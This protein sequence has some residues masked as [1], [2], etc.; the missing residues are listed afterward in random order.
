MEQMLRDLLARHGRL[1]VTAD[2]IG[3]ND[4]LHEAG[5]TSLATVDVMLAIEAEFDIEIP[6]R[7][8][9][10][11]SF[12]SLSRLLDMVAACKAHA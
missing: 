11:Q 1:S 9:N 8:L 7:L 12:G 6:D 5:L 3:L 2:R 10:R 4:D